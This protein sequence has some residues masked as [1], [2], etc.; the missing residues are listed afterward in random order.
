[1][2][3]CNRKQEPMVKGENYHISYG[4]P[5]GTEIY[6]YSKEKTSQIAEVI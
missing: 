6:R 3:I 5:V 1:M 4:L 2:G